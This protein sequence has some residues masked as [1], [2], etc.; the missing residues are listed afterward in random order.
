METNNIIVCK[1]SGSTTEI[2]QRC[3]HGIRKASISMIKSACDTTIDTNPHTINIFK[4]IIYP[5]FITGFKKKKICSVWS[6]TCQISL[7][8]TVRMRMITD[9]W[10]WI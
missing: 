10:T 8:Q 3:D 1:R 5:N 2:T 7:Q 4:R 6:T 9:L